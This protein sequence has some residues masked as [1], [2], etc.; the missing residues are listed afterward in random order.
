[1]DNFRNNFRDNHIV[2]VRI[3]ATYGTERLFSLV[4]NAYSTKI[5]ILKS[6]WP[7]L[8]LDGFSLNLYFLAIANANVT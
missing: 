3:C 2:F 4:S 5:I 7:Y 1:M 6:V 8:F